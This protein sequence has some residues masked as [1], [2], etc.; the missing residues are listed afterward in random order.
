MVVRSEAGWSDSTVYAL[1]QLIRP[2]DLY[3][4]L[5]VLIASKEK[6]HYYRMNKECNKV[7]RK[8]LLTKQIPD[9]ANL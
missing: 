4:G 9:P 3:V 8:K 2:V 5:R 6:V 1:S 7:R